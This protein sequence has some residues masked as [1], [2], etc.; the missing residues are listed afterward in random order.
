MAVLLISSQYFAL[1]GL[2]T[3]LGLL[4]TGK[5]WGYIILLCTVAFVGK[6]AGCAIAARV[7]KFNLRESATIGVL[8]SCKGLVLIL[9]TKG[10]TNTAFE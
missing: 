6:F 1:S 3:N 9:K 5:I 10:S 8:M 4:N 2:N 7:F